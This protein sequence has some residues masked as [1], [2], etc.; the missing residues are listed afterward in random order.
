MSGCRR[1]FDPVMDVTTVALV[2]GSIR[3]GSIH[4][5][6]ASIV[7]DELRRRGVDPDVID[8]TDFPLPI[9]HGDEE[10]EHGVPDA[11]VRLHERLDRHDGLI[12]F[13]PE[14]N[15]GP[16][17]LL[18]NSID[19]VT[20]VERA[21]LQRPLV[22]FAAA[23]PG[24]RGA[25]TVLSVMRSIGAHLSMRMV[26]DDFSLPHAG[27]AFAEAGESWRLARADDAARLAGW[28]D[29]FVAGLADG[30]S[31]VEDGDGR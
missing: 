4:R 8:L 24:G 28:I 17:A 22:G 25:R 13:T 9:Y 6:L 23:S 19:W 14:Y 16:S 1:P 7:A 2:S 29:D 15:G 30:A 31:A 5:R 26:A 12:V 11:A 21:V 10:A 20:R 3:A 27:D 18:K